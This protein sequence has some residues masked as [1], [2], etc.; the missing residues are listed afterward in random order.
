MPPEISLTTVRIVAAT[1][2]VFAAAAL[3]FLV[4]RL[5]FNR[6]WAYAALFT[7][8][9]FASY[10][11]MTAP[12]RT[13]L[14]GN[15]GD[16]QFIT[17]FFARVLDGQPF[18]DFYYQGLPP[19]YPPLYFWIVGAISGPFVA[20]GVT[21]AKIGAGLVFLA[22]FAVPYAFNRWLWA[23]HR[24]MGGG[25]VDPIA[26][27]P[28]F[29]LLFPLCFFLSTDFYALT[30]KPFETL[31][32]LIAICWIGGV[33][34]ALAWPRWDARVLLTFGIVG[35]LLFLTYY[36]WWFILIPTTL[37]VAL[38]TRP[39]RRSLLRVAGIGAIMLIVSLPYTLPL[40]MSFARYGIE[41][42]QA[43]FFTIEDFHSYAP[44]ASLSVAG[45]LL[46]AGAVG[47]WRF[48]HS[49]YALAA[50]LT[51]IFCYAYQ[52]ANLAVTLAGGKS[53]MAA[54][55]FLFLGGAALSAGTAYAAVAAGG[56]IDRRY[57]RP[58]LDAAVLAALLLTA[59]LF[60]F[61][62]FIEEPKTLGH[63][64]RALAPRGEILL[65]ENIRAAVPDWRDRV[66]L[67]SGTASLNAY[68]PLYY[69]VAQSPH[70]SHQA[71]RYS[72]RFAAVRDLAAAEDAAAFDRL[73]A[74]RTD[75]SAMVLFKD[76]ARP[77]SYP[78]FFWQDAYPNGGRDVRVDLRRSLI[79]E[80][81]WEKVKEDDDWVIFVAH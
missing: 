15:T 56:W 19:F 11:V 59:P 23:R 53:A 2:L 12:L 61:G 47:L 34:Q 37:A 7:A 44:W 58:A 42:W 79:D 64:E 33:R 30:L 13:L 43:V 49:A 67:S 76:P 28:W 55:P 45:L 63:L 10:A 52:A 21:A 70:F 4:L 62:R 38:L 3:L 60:P 22:W 31:S 5:R 68:L 51:L 46:L 27:S 39:A 18:S 29:W 71:S 6:P 48:R 74:E 72:E 36:F 25:A 40:A 50:G 16:E 17:A 77:E 41:N 81:R 8:A 69:F 57:G 26:A 78:L 54:K 32:A 9:I 80:A 73:I 14:G 24:R 65:A 75:V 66:W 35:G 20:S 1:K